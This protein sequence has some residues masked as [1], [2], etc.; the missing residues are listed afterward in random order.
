MHILREHCNHLGFIIEEEP[1]AGLLPV[2]SRAEP[3]KKIG[4][5]FSEV[6]A[7]VHMRKER[8]AVCLS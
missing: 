2:S 3:E 5:V 8:K 4:P 7:M 6:P 1:G